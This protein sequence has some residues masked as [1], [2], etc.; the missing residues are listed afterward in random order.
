MLQRVSEGKKTWSSDTVADARLYATLAFRYSTDEKH[1]L[2]PILN[3][4]L[5]GKLC[6][7]GVKLSPGG[8]ILCSPL[9]SSKQ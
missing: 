5:R 7:P 9:L 3:F 8:E 2:R 4:A 1:L 6:P